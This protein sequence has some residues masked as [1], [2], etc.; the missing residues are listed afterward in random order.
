MKKI[1]GNRK[2]ISTILAALLMVVI[3]VVASVMVYAWSTGLLGGLLV[4]PQAGKEVLNMESYTFNSANTVATLFI[5]NTGSADI[6]LQS[7]YV[8]NGTATAQF[9]KTTGWTAGPITVN[10]VLQ[11]SIDITGGT[12][13]YTAGHSYEVTVV[14]TRNNQFKFTIIR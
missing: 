5:R 11:V 1:L 13:T 9:A 3:V 14:T 6:T 8:S 7:Y 4:T 10:N 2:A 12:F